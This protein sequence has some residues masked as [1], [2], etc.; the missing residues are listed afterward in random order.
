MKTF[1]W[2]LS[3]TLTLGTFGFLQ[4]FFIAETGLGYI[5]G[6]ICLIL[7]IVFFAF[8]VVEELN[9]EISRL[10]GKIRHY[11]KLLMIEDTER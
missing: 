6:L 1:N 10:K 7:S 8:G 11:E 9:K 4:M 2:I 3:C 5:S